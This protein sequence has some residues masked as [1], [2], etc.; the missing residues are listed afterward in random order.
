MAQSPVTIVGLSSAGTA[1]V[2][3]GGFLRNLKASLTLTSGSSTPEGSVIVAAGDNPADD[4]IAIL[5]VGNPAIG[6][7]HHSSV[8]QNFY[9]Y[10]NVLTSGMSSAYFSAI[11][12]NIY[13]DGPQWP[14]L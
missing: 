13:F 10:V 9:Q 1:S 6:S 11:T 8:G 4:S 5:S 7:Y 12:V 2:Y 3:L 14:S